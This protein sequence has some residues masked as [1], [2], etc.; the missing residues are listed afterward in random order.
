MRR[1]NIY[2]SMSGNGRFELIKENNLP[3]GSQEMEYWAECFTWE[4]LKKVIPYFR[5]RGW[6][7]LIEPIE[8]EDAYG[9]MHIFSFTYG[10]N[11]E[12]QLVDVMGIR[13]IMA[14]DI[15]APKAIKDSF[16]PRY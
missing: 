11:H 13:V 6:K 3:H 1:Y 15:I 14:R 12:I 16:T 10:I 7:L 8:E 4:D 5:A 9:K 2:T